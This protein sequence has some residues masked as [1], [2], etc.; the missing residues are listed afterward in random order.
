[1]GLSHLLEYLAGLPYWKKGE[2]EKERER[3]VRKLRT[4]KSLA[5]ATYLDT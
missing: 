4:T 3:K 1:M 2:R 5:R